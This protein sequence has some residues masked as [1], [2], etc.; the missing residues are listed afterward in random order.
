MWDNGNTL[1]LP[2][3]RRR[4][5]CRRRCWCPRRPSCG[6]KRWAIV[7]PELRVRPVGDG[8]V[9]EADDRAAAAASSSSRAGDAARQDRR[10][11]RSCRRWPTPSPTRSSSSLF[12]ADLAKFVR[13][14]NT[15]R[16]VQGPPVFNLLAGEP[17]YLD[18]LKDEAPV[19]WYRHR[20]SVVRDRDARA[21]AASSTPTRR[22]TTTIRGWARWS[23]TAT[24]MSVAA[25]IKKARSTDTEKL[26]AAMQRPR[27]RHAVRQG[28]RTAR[29]TTSRR[30]APTSAGSASRTARA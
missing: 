19:G 12:G 26:I 13:E 16:P 10:R 21:Q 9:Q 29:S 8:R 23:A 4:P 27:R 3:A 15:A 1:H 20:L 22:S 6:K 25:G 30:W 24:I 14:G 11:R 28:R 7:Y 17:E 5:T 18:P 2:P